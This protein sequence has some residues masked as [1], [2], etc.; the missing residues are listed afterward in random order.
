MMRYVVADVI[1]KVS[2]D[3]FNVRITLVY[4]V[5]V[6]KQRDQMVLPS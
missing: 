4:V 3:T 2:T 6:Y 5:P 1:K